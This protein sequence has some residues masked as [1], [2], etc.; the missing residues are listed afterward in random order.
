MENVDRTRFA[1]LRGDHHRRVS[2]QLKRHLEALAECVE[3][4]QAL[5]GDN[6]TSTNRKKNFLVNLIAQSSLKFSK[7]ETDDSNQFML[8]LES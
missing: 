6:P 3:N 1:V 5:H 2:G 4:L 7:Q 8:I